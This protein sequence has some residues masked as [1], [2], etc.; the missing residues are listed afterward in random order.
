[1]KYEESKYIDAHPDDFCVHCGKLLKE[2]REEYP[3]GDGNVTQTFLMCPN[4][5]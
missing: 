5:D 1:M 2:V 3:Y 4:C